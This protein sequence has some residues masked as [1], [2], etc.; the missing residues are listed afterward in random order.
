[1]AKVWEVLTQIA[2]LIL[3][4]LMGIG[5]LWLAGFLGCFYLGS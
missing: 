4:I 5:A 1:M 3:I 2:I